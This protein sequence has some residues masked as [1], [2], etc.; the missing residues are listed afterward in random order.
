MLSSAEFIQKSLEY[1]LFWVR[2]MKEHAVFIAASV[3]PTL[4][5]VAQQA[6]YYRQQFAILLSEAVRLASGLVSRA[7]LQSGQYYT[8]Y[9]EAAEQAVQQLTGLQTDGWLTQ[10]E[11][12]IAPLTT[13]TITPQTEEAVRSLNTYI[14]NMVHGL[15][16]LKTDLLN[17]QSACR[18]FTFLYTADLNHILHEAQ[19]Y[20]QILN[21]LQNRDENFNADY[22]A[23]WNRNMSDHAKSMRGLFDPTETAFIGE[24]DR[25]AQVFDALARVP[26]MTAAL[27]ETKDISAFKATAT[28]GMLACKVKSIMNPLYTDHL[29]REANHYVWLLQG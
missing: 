17:N 27:A 9:T 23:F 22:A 10:L 21:G 29:L 11:Y 20:I 24:A 4:Q 16:A 3:P 28:Q 25:Y 1:D 19:R 5:H 2:I 15:A 8:K 14:L 13:M 12:N 6:E 26:N 18:I 7:A